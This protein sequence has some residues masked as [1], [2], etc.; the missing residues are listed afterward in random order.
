M[1]VGSSFYRVVFENGLFERFLQ[2]E[3]VINCK[4]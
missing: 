1:Q 4:S 3:S 2:F